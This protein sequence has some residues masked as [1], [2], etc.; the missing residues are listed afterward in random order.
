MHG[1]FPSSRKVLIL[2]LGPR[3]GL[4]ELLSA[5]FIDNNKIDDLQ[6]GSVRSP[7]SS[8]VRPGYVKRRCVCD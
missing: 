5:V 7:E 4:C 6:L 1:A 2:S 3:G 8:A